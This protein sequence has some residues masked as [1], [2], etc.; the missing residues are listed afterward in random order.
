MYLS[1]QINQ[2]ESQQQWVLG[3]QTNLSISL[4]H[5]KHKVKIELIMSM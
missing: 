1:G 3:I 5:T 4:R 2:E